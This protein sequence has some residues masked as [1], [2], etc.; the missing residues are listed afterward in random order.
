DGIGT[1]EY[2]VGHCLAHPDVRNLR[3]HIV[4]AFD[5]LDIDRGID[6]DAVTHHLFDIEVAFGVPA[7]LNIGVSEFV[8]Q[9]DLRTPRN[10]GVQVHFGE[11]LPFV[12]NL[13]AWNDL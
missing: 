4:E 7:A 12:F 13:S 5:V 1:I 2:C 9:C 8:D 6:V 11:Q 10:D 3:N